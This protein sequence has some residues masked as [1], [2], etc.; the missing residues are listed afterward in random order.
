MRL[1][2]G[3]I[4]HLSKLII[5]RLSEN[6]MV[7]FLR[8]PNDVRLHIVLTISKELEIEDVIDAVVRKTID[9][10]SRKILEGSNEWEVIY[11]KLYNEEM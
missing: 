8:Q 11:N 2:R 7:E 1:S 6:K 4:N 3:K 5:K 10:Y 9:S